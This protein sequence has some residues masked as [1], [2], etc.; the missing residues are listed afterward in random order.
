MK[1]KINNT[2][3]LLAVLTISSLFLCFYFPKKNSDLKYNQ[4]TL[5]QFVENI[6][7]KED[8][9][10]S[11]FDLNNQMTGLMSQDMFCRITTSE[12][13]LL[14]EMA[15]EKPVLIYRFT[16]SSCE[17]CYIDALLELEKEIQKEFLENRDYVKV[18]CSLQTERELM[19]LRRTY[20]FSYP[21]YT[22]SYDAFKWIAEE[23]HKPYY[24]VL[25]PDMKISHIYVPDK[26]Y[27][28]LNKQYLEG[29]NRFLS[30]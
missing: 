21:I 3:G 17:V 14:S 10:Q 1:R 4:K 28:E 7:I 16:S 24:F 30:D 25:H 19:I 11:N 9:L 2:N 8:F 23:S 29:V 22:I 13:R 5:L 20:K 15:K 12:G 18:L 6:Q 27:S 26:N